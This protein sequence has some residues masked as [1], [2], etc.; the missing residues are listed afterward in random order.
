VSAKA[1]SQR[2]GTDHTELY[3]DGKMAME[4]I[5]ELPSIYDEPFAD[6]SQIPTWLVSKL[7]REQV[8]VALSGDGADEFF[9]GYGRYRSAVLPWWRG[10]RAMRHRGILDGKG[11]AVFNG[12][13]KVERDAQKASAHQENRNLLLSDDATV[14][15]KPHLEIDADDI[16]ASHG[17]TIGA[18]DDASL[19]YLRSRGIGEELAR[20]IL[21][22]AF[23]HELLDRIPH[24]PVARRLG[25]ALLARMPNGESIRELLG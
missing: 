20:D 21:T 9:A 5:P 15:T 10:G 13:I 11:G 12:I 18:I 25:E 7:A 23:V 3:V 17:A 16:S 1:V 2:L 4:V 14:H 19:F 22:F 24:A 6:N 8:T